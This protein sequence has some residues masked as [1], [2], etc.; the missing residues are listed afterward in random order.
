MFQRAIHHEGEL[1][2]SLDDNNPEKPTKQYAILNGTCLKFYIC[3]EEW[4]NPSKVIDLTEFHSISN[5]KKTKYFHLE[6]KSNS[7]SDR[8]KLKAVTRKDKLEWIKTLRK[9]LDDSYG[10]TVKIDNQ[11]ESICS[12]W[13]LL[14]CIVMVIL[15]VVPIAITKPDGLHYFAIVLSQYEMA[16]VVLCFYY[17][18]QFKWNKI[19][20]VMRLNKFW[21]EKA[22][23]FL[24]NF[25]AFLLLTI[26]I[27]IHTDHVHLWNFTYAATF[28][29]GSFSI[30]FP[31]V[32]VKLHHEL[33]YNENNGHNNS[34]VPSPT[35]S[36]MQLVPTHN[37]QQ[38]TVKSFLEKIVKLP[39]YY[40]TFQRENINT[41][42]TVREL[43]NEDLR[44]MKIA[45]GHR[46]RI[47]NYIQNDNYKQISVMSNRSNRTTVS[48]LFASKA[49]FRDNISKGAIC[50]CYMVHFFAYIGFP[51]LYNNKYD[52]LNSIIY[53]NYDKGNTFFLIMY[54]INQ[55]FLRTFV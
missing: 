2:V 38:E 17:F 27:S 30:P 10:T 29:F 49:I 3:K 41:M 11:V 42:T 12:I 24:Y 6:P 16:L 46:K 44:E 40:E 33:K 52:E 14:S 20:Q 47:L 54:N 34:P 55:I 7:K 18:C 31:A 25:I 9:I 35:L 45:I 13:F 43:T 51:L 21:I 19:R 22:L 53:Y 28:L 50:L 8:I 48:V 1:V 15:F 36:S 26:N 37:Q 23:C 39:Q 32:C 4:T 5:S